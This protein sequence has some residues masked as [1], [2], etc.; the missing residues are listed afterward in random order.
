[1][2]AQSSILP[3]FPFFPGNNVTP[4]PPLP[5]VGVNVAPPPP[6]PPVGANV[7]PPPPLPAPQPLSNT[8]PPPPPANS[9]QT[10][11]GNDAIIAD[12]QNNTIFGSGGNDTIDGSTGTDTL[13]YNL[14]QSITLLAGGVV[15]KGALGQDKINNIETIVGSPNQA[16]TIDGSTGT[17]VA[18]LNINLSANSLAVNDLPTIGTL[19]FTVQNF[20]NAIGTPNIDS[21]TGNDLN[22]ALTAGAGSDTINAG[23]GDDAIIGVNPNDATPGSI[24]NDL[25]FG[26]FGRDLFVLG[27]SNKAFYTGAG[28]ATISDFEKGIDRIQL[29]GNISDYAIT[30]NSISRAGDLIATVNT[31]IGLADLLFV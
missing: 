15:N 27:Q 2:T 9:I 16:N 17:G 3:P 26:G 7:A 13:I 29:A 5:P 12:S 8:T 6:L 21:I 4:P 18:S 24:E 20:V 22:N 10:T 11:T 19:N 14:P 1:M 25:L 23:G 31:G 30:G 28:G